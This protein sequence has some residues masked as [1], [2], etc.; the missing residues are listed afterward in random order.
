M[1]FPL[2]VLLSTDAFPP[3]C[4]GS[5]WSTYEL[6]KGL[7]ARGHLVDIVKTE[8]GRSPG[9]YEARY[10]SFRVTT[11]RGQVPDLPV[12]RNVLKNE[13]MWSDPQRRPASVPNEPANSLQRS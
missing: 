5:G 10:E 6:A 13:K 8:I 7:S 1:S 4:G 9:V 2:R 3:I 12:V 11:L